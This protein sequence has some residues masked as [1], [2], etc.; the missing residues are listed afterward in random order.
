[1]S[2]DFGGLE[3]LFLVAALR[4]TVLLTLV[5]FIGG[6]LGGF[7]VAL[8]R[9]SPNRAVRLQHFPGTARA[10]AQPRAAPL[11]RP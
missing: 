1:M 10:I 9:T 7:A 5:A 6:G 11:S 3:L 4:W 2:R 8:M